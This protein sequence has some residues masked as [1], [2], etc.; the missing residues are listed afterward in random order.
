[1]NSGDTILNYLF[2]IGAI[3][4]GNKY[5]APRIPPEFHERVHLPFL[6]FTVDF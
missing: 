1:M 4:N 5:G 6:I 2:N 3:Q